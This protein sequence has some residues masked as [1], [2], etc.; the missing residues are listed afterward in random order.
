MQSQRNTLLRRK[1]FHVILLFVILPI[2]PLESFSQWK[3]HNITA[4]FRWFNCKMMAV[5]SVY[6]TLVKLIR[7]HLKCIHPTSIENGHWLRSETKIGHFSNVRK[8]GRLR[9]DWRIQKFRLISLVQRKLE[10]KMREKIFFIN[11]I[12]SFF[13][14]S[15]FSNPFFRDSIANWNFNGIIDDDQLQL[16]AIAM[17]I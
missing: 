7:S 14:N 15:T 16:N 13:K 3:L 1:M 8:C 17:A 2:H 9:F 10:K 4:I 6:S 12:L 11:E 5:N